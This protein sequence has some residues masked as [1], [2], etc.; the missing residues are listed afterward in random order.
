MLKR[1]A[2]AVLSV[3]SLSATHSMGSVSQFLFNTSSDVTGQTHGQSFKADASITHLTTCEFV[4]FSNTAGVSATATLFSG[5]GYG[6]PVLGTQ[7]LTFPS[8]VPINTP[9]GFDFTGTTL[10]PGA[11]YTIS[12]ISTPNLVLRAADFNPYADGAMLD[13]MGLP[14]SGGN[15]DFKF[16]FSG[17]VPEPASLSLVV[18][19][20][21]MG[22]RRR[23]ARQPR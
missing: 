7:T 5:V 19:A 3:L 1:L 16:L 17:T 8:V 20:A 22:C 21:A 23:A 2:V 15:R 11:D 13:Y 14:M 12:L 10:T 6:G 9:A 4:I 18:A